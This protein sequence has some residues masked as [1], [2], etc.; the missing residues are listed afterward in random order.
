MTL[1][2]TYTEAR[3]KFAA[4][5]DHAVEAREP[6]IV[7]RRGHEDVA[8]IAA[9]E[10]AALQETA[11]LLRSPANAARLLEALADSRNRRIPTTTIEQLRAEY[12]LAEEG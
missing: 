8:I 4:A 9:D 2:M 1:V 10:L 12:G 11:Y 5:Y 3:Q 6:V 7:R